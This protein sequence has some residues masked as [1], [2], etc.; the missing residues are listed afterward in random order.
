MWGWPGL[1]ELSRR[2][3]QG[4]LWG[5]RIIS[6]SPGL[7]GEP[8]QWPGT[9]FVLTADQAPAA[10]AEQVAAG[11]RWI[12]VYTRLTLPA[13]Q[14][15]MAEAK[16]AGLGVVGH[17][18]MAVP[19]ETALD[20]GQHSIEHLTGYD[21]RFSPGRSGTWAWIAPD[22]ALYQ[23]LALRTEATGAWNCPTLAIFSELAKQ[24]GAAQRQEILE[25]RR[26]FVQALHRAGARLLAGSDA[27]IDIVAPGESLH[28]E[29]RELVAAGLTPYQALRAATIDAGEFL[30]LP[31]LGTVVVGA[32]A[33]LLLVGG[34]PLEGIERIRR[35][36]G[37]I[38]RGAWIPA[39][40]VPAS[41]PPPE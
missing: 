3:E 10:V 39:G 37:L 36:D 25:H 11:W 14:A 21:T 18:P 38:H 9:R 12:K 40:S 6:A 5:P 16:K 24:H 29:L 33:D 30:E 41:V 32:P 28:D 19:I 31:G 26:A 13:Y 4:E 35:F 17:V 20:L 27:G 15:I 7:D 1:S 23:L 8:A 22:T 34:N 2:I